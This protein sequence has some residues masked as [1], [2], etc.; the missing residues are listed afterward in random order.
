MDPEKR[1]HH[2]HHQHHHRRH[3]RYKIIMRVIWSLIGLLVLVTLFFAGIAWRNVRNATSTMY[4]P[5][6]IKTGLN[7]KLKSERPINVLLLGTD[8]G[9]LGR[10]YKGRTDTI[11]MMT[12]NPKREKT[13][14]VSLPRDMQVNLP[15]FV[16][17]SPSKI[18]AAYTYG[19][20]KETIKTVNKYFQV[21]IDG[22]LLVNMGG[23]EKSIDQIGGV[24]VTSPLTFDY[25]GYHF[26]KGTTYH[27]NGKKALA[28]S[29]MR[30][31]DPEGDYGRQKRQRLIIMALLK[32]TAS[33][34]AVLN[35]DFLNSIA[36]EAQ[37][38][39]SLKDMTK[40]ALNYRDA[41]KTVKSDHAQG[42]GQSVDG[43]AFEVI[44]SEERQRVSNEIRTALELK[45]VNL[46][47]N[48]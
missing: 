8:T 32:E 11:M 22:Y 43:V 9:A 14:I 45:T 7:K 25:E 31:D 2:H 48:D 47:E 34:K 41:A 3:H 1:Q 10:S 30:Y 12:V 26:T 36:N 15:D 17:E 46:T 29:R 28:F 44:P 35:Q 37:T 5:S 21:P 27:M 23:L 39:F 18:N 16:D 24:D 19:G 38:D 33:Y 6:G 13:T 42:H 40:L 20:V 4:S